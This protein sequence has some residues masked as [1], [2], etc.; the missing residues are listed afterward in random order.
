MTILDAAKKDIG[1]KENPGGHGFEDKIFQAAMMESGYR[2]GWT[3]N[4]IVLL[5]WIRDAYPEKAKYLAILFEHSAVVTFRNL[6]SAGLPVSMVPTVGALVYWQRME[7]GSPIWLGR[8]GVVSRVASDW[9]F[10][11]IEGNIV[12]E[13]VPRIVE[14][15]VF[16]GLKVIGFVTV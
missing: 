13:E 12:V 9:E 8:A 11:S 14:K 15:E 16:D 1:I 7:N 10:Y 3:W 6:E 5:K 2:M 4:S